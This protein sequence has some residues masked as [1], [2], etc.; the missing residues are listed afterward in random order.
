[1]GTV[2]ESQSQIPKDMRTARAWANKEK[3]IR[4]K[5]KHSV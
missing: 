3:E 1:M 5:I 2:S 4:A